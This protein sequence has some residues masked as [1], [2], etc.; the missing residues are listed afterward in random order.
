MTRDEGIE[1]VLEYDH[2]RP[3]RDLAR[4]LDYVDMPE[5][6]FNRVADSFR[7]PRVWWVES[8]R[9]H[10]HCIDGK[11]RGYELVAS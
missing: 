2:V 10:K 5:N 4:W 9:W 11:V 1:M 7:D 3:T 6:E 8:G